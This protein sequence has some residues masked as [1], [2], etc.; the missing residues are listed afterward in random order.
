MHRIGRTG[1]VQKASRLNKGK[2]AKAGYAITFICT[3]DQERFQE[4]EE[5][6]A[7]DVIEVDWDFKRV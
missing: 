7:A 6:Y 4:I 3:E 1:R 2:T 5:M